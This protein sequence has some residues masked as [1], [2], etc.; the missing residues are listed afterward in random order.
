MDFMIALDTKGLS[1]EE[2][3]WQEWAEDTN[4]VG[5]INGRRSETGRFHVET[6]NSKGVKTRRD[7]TPYV[8]IFNEE[9]GKYSVLTDDDDM[10]FPDSNFDVDLGKNT[11]QH[12]GISDQ[13][14]P[15]MY[16]SLKD[17]GCIL[18]YEG[19]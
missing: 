2:M 1:P 19:C 15:G 16:A 7:I 9:E 17:G 12:V 11:W 6:Y 13:G 18:I 10:P 4:D 5:I 8:G 3:E 14:R